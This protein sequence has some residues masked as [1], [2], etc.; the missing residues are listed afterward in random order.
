MR[1][2]SPAISPHHRRRQCRPHT[3]VDYLPSHHHDGRLFQMAST[4]TKNYPTPITPP[5]RNIHPTHWPKTASE[6]DEASVIVRLLDSERRHMPRQDYLRLRRSRPIHLI[7]RQNSINYILKVHAAYRFKPVTAFL[8]VNYF[9]RFLSSHTLPESG[10][11]F[12]LLSVACLSLA[13]KMEEMYVPLLMD[14]QIFEPTHIFESKTVQRMELCVMATLDWRLRSVTPFDYLHYFASK[15][16]SAAASRFHSILSLA[17]DIILS[18]A[19]VMDFSIFPPSVM[20][21]AA[22]MISAAGEAESLISLENF[23]ERVDR[24]MVSSCHQL[25]DQYLADTGSAG[26]LK[27]QLSPPRSPVGLFDAAAGPGSE[28]QGAGSG[29]ASDQFLPAQRSAE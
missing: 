28:N 22:L 25:M 15:V 29:M 4:A 14:L 10:W 26:H 21:A 11:P 18:S 2:H 7:A 3:A 19:R 16:P 8:S 17:S 27:H 20:S 12:Q 1:V 9:D 6:S 13:A 5:P 23:N 24:E